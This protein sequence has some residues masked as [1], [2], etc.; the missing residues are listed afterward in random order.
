MLGTGYKEEGQE[1]RGPDL[2][3]PEATHTHQSPQGS[4]CSPNS[5]FR[6]KDTVSDV[7]HE[8]EGPR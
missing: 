7:S 2:A 1:D 5:Q 6:E 4:R 3:K 8:Q